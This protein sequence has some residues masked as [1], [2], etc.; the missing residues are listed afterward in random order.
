MKEK[1]TVHLPFLRRRPSVIARR[2]PS[3]YRCIFFALILLLVAATVVFASP[4][5]TLRL[6][7]GDAIRIALTRS[8]S[9]VTAAVTRSQGAITLARG[10]GSVLPTVSGAI[11]TEQSEGN[12]QWEWASNITVSQVIFSP[13]VFSGLVSSALS[14]SSNRL[15]SQDQLATLVYNVT[16]DYLNMLKTRKLW[17]VATT[18]LVR[19]KRNFELVQKKQELGMV[20]SIDLLRAQVQESQAQLELIQAERNLT[21]ANSEFIATAGIDREVAIVPVDEFIAPPDSEIVNPDNLVQEIERTNLSRR[22]AALS[23]TIAAVNTAAAFGSVLPDVNLYW[24]TE[25]TGNSFSSVFPYGQN[26]GEAKYGIQVKFPLLDLK[27]YVLNVANA[28]NEAHRTAAAS[29]A[30]TLWLHT[31]ATDAVNGYLQAQTAFKQ[32]R[33]NLELNERLHKLAEEQ[34]KLG[35]ISQVDYLEIEN[36]LV[37]AQSSYISAICEIYNQAALIAYLKGI[38]RLRN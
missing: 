10:I 20:S 23:K 24:A 9:K 13:S 26:N 17:D 33:A 34:L 21:K 6:T 36:A 3:V 11:S 16:V 30:T 38:I 5:D 31:T 2:P 1:K 14:Y 15:S 18:A 25:R 32:A 7:L 22:M 19:A 28:V 35:M 8:P 4:A 27:S 29:R 12:K 37:K